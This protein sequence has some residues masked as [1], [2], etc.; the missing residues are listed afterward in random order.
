MRRTATI[1]VIDDSDIALDAARIALEDRGH[2]VV[3]LGNALI[4]QRVVRS[5]K[6]DLILID[7][8]MPLLGGDRAVEILS[9]HGAYGGVPVVLFSDLPEDELQERARRCGAAGWV[10][11]TPDEAALARHVERWLSP[12]S[13][14]V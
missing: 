14:P 11:K 9:K 8:N 4:M 5:E 1:L 6:P 13:K 12:E 7:V 10:R 3:T 2:R